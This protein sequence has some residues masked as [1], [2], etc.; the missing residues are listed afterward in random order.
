MAG[1][2]RIPLDHAIGSFGSLE[3][4]C[5]LGNPIVLWYLLKS[6]AC[7]NSHDFSHAVNAVM[8]AYFGQSAL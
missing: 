5:C 2:H 1:C 3:L 6:T 7:K 4:T 8:T